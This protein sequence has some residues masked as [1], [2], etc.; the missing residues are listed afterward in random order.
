[1]NCGL[2]FSRLLNLFSDR[3][4]SS[5]FLII[6]ISIF[7]SSASNSSHSFLLNARHRYKILISIMSIKVN[8]EQVW[9]VQYPGKRRSDVYFLK[10]NKMF[11]SHKESEVRIVFQLIYTE[12]EITNLESESDN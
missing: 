8:K 6:F 10:Q 12:D 3:S 9:V 1:M 2:T 4:N 7:L 11:T 5:C